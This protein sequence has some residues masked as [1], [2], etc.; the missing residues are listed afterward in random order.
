M[1]TKI[2]TM[3]RIILPDF[4]K[5]SAIAGILLIVLAAV[6]IFLPS[7]M[8][9]EVMILISSLL[10][11]GGIFWLIHTFKYR[12]REWTEWLKPSL[13]LVVGGLMA[14]YPMA[15]IAMIGLLL[16][17]YLLIDAYSS[18]IMAYSL[19]HNRG[20][21]WM[22]FNGLVSLLL[23]TLFLV[24]WPASSLWLVGLYIS[25]SLLFDGVS[26]LSIYWLQRKYKHVV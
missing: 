17:T 7:V 19:R 23:A 4:G 20:W 12:S 9:L 22:V 1:N 11:I 24:G 6:G 15:G 26:L 18:F 16:A 10:L 13:L 21:I 5:F 25:I 2:E 8:S 3:T 14:F